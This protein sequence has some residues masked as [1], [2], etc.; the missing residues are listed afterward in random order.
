MM[1]ITKAKIDMAARSFETEIC[2]CHCE[3]IGETQNLRTLKGLRGLVG[4]KW[5]REVYVVEALCASCISIQRALHFGRRLFFLFDNDNDKTR[6]NRHDRADTEVLSKSVSSSVCAEDSKTNVC[7]SHGQTEQ[8]KLEEEPTP[9]TSLLLAVLIRL[10]CVLAVVLGCTCGTAGAVQILGL[11]LDDVV[12]V[13]ELA[14]LGGE[15]E[16]GDARELD[17]GDFEARGPFVFLLVHQLEG[18]RLFLKVGDAGLGRGVR[19]TETACLGRLSVWV[20][21]MGCRARERTEH[22]ASSL[23]LPSCPWS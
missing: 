6:D 19:I 18:E 21:Q 12:V 13:G 20:E 14:S 4:W 1:I 9:A 5:Y 2:G 23:A 17:T 10:V 3:N 22:P 16:V 11:D 8:D 15:T 7:A